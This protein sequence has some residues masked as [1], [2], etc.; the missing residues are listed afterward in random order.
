MKGNRIVAIMVV[1]A[2]VLSTMIVLNTFDIRIVEK[3]EATI[4]VDDWQ[5]SSTGAGADI[6]NMTT[7]DLYYN[8]KV[9]LEFNGSLINGSTGDCRLYKPSYHTEY[10]TGSGLYEVWT[11]WT[12]VGGV[13]SSTDDVPTLTEVNLTVAGLWLVCADN[14]PSLYEVNMSDLQ[15]YDI[16]QTTWEPIVGWF[17][18]NSSEWTVELSKNSVYYDKNES[19]TITVRKGGSTVTGTGWI[20]IWNMAGSNPSLVYHKELTAAMEG[21]WTISNTLMYTLT[22]SI[23]AGTYRVTAYEDIDPDH[24]EAEDIY[25]LEGGAS[26]DGEMGYNETFGDVVDWDGRFIDSGTTTIIREWD[27]GQVDYAGLDGWNQTTYRWDSCG[28]FDPPEYWA[29]YENFTVEPGEPTFKISNETIFWNET[30]STNLDIN[31]TDYDGNG[32]EFPGATDVILYNKS[33]KPTRAGAIPVNRT[34]YAVTSTAVG[35]FWRITI[36]PNGSGDRWGWNKTNNYVWAEK[37][38]LYI[39]IHRTTVGNATDE[40]NDTAEIDLVSAK[41]SFKWIND[42]SAPNTD[43]ELLEIPAIAAVPYDFRFQIVGSEYEYWGDGSDG[44]TVTGAAENITIT[45]DSLFTGKLDKFPSFDVGWFDGTT[46]TVPMIPMMAQNGGEI[47]I[48]AKAWNK[49]ITGIL[50]I[51]GSKYWNNGSVI[52]V[53]PNEFKI[54]EVNRTLSITVKDGTGYALRGADVYLYYIDDTINGGDPVQ[55]HEVSHIT[56]DANGEYS[57][58]FNISQ[59]TDNQTGAPPDGAGLADIMAPRNLT[60]YVVSSAGYGYAKI[61]MTPIND[62][63]V[64]LSRT[65]FLAGYSYDDWYLNCTF[66]GNSTE[67]PHEDDKAEFFIKIYNETGSD[68]TDTLLSGGAYTSADLTNDADY[69]YDLTDVYITKPGTYTVYCKNSTHDSTGF[70]ATF[71]VEQVTVECN[72]SE[73]IWKNDDNVSALFSVTYLGAP[74]NGSLVI[75]N[76]S[77]AGDYNMTWTN[78]SFDGTSDQGGNSSIEV[79]EDD[80]ENGQV[81]ISDITASYLHPDY[82]QQNITFWFMP[83]S[84][85]D[86]AYAQAIGVVPVKI[87]DVTPMPG[88]IPYSEP[89]ELEIKL[90][91]RGTPLPDLLVNISIPGISGEMSTRTDANGVALFA[92][93]PPTTGDIAIEVENRTTEVEVPVTSWKLYVDSQPEVDEGE[94]FV[95]TIRNGTASG[96]GLAGATV[97]FNRITKTTDADGQATF[98]APAVTSDREF[99]ILGSKDGFAEDTE[100]IV[101]VNKPQL[102]IVAPAKKGTGEEFKVTIADDAGNPIIGATVTINQKS[103]TSGGEGIA[104]LTGPSDEGTYEITATKTGFADADPVQIKIEGRIP[105]FELLTLIAAIGVAFILL[106]RRRN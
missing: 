57:M 41:A 36:V 13:I 19:L 74:I 54:D 58:I 29:D 28:P 79:D 96:S 35:D 47:R 83:E 76:I 99:T 81:K 100:M 46:W 86:G 69:S 72:L 90:T 85:H 84:P 65:T 23:G 102:V 30:R 52:T 61:L 22:H 66:A 89:A 48:T 75:D 40:W 62:L 6:L 3:A 34:Y 45:G 101:V 31:A 26:K 87:A 93:T 67:T 24:A 44:E 94:D 82:A 33:N 88:S 14:P 64:E 15:I 5:S 63:E 51:G 60:L 59:Q 103:V 92:F 98:I 38:K 16:S 105:G 104:T 11:N 56:S 4:G 71:V 20:D 80:L 97:K 9:D 39:V 25:G 10:D 95:V 70:N 53:T 50:T 21:V 37:G 7:E 77:S 106:R 42:G 32:L 17:W 18:V 73:F 78:T 2:L 91:G 43:G 49:S 1:L 27:K 55:A 8:Q 68:V 12:R